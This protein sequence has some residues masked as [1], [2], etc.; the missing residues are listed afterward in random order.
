VLEGRII[1]AVKELLDPSDLENE[2][3]RKEEFCDKEGKKP[4]FTK[5]CD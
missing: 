1:G 2:E 3:S 5:F 4:E